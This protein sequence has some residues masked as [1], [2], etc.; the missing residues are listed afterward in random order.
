[1]FGSMFHFTATFRTI[2][3]LFMNCFLGCHCL[4]VSDSPLRVLDQSESSAKLSLLETITMLDLA[5]NVMLM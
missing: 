2:D 1:M 4:S 3:L 5:T